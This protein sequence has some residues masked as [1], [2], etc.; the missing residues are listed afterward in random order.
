MIQTLGLAA[1]AAGLADVGLAADA[2]WSSMSVFM[3]SITYITASWAA[4]GDR[5]TQ[6]C[7]TDQ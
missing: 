1:D 6:C 7:E 4:E 2:V 5:P 3:M